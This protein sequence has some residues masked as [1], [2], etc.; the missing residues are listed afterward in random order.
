MESG[1]SF[2]WRI[3]VA[4]VAL[5]GRQVAAYAHFTARG[6]TEGRY[7]NVSQKIDADK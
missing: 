2:G 5:D 3:D 4:G 6:R 1:R 7:H